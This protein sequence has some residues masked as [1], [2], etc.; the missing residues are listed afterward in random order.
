MK[1]SRIERNFFLGPKVD[2]FKEDFTR[3]IQGQNVDF[4]V[5]IRYFLNYYYYFFFLKVIFFRCQ[6]WFFLIFFNE[7]AIVFFF[8]STERGIFKELFLELF[9]VFFSRTRRELL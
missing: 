7:N 4:L 1:F 8:S 6:T 3:I 9:D 5:L 2:F